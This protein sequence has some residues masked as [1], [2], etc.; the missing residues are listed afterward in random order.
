MLNIIVY[1]LTGLCITRNEL[2]NH[3]NDELLIMGLIILLVG[4]ILCIMKIMP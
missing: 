3:N 4:T 1:F 2:L